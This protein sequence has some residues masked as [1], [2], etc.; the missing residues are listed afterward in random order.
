MHNI[1]LHKVQ[2]KYEMLFN[3]F[4]TIQEGAMAISWLSHEIL[5]IPQLSQIRTPGKQNKALSKNIR[6]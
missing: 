1:G 2:L 6:F 4:Y 5:A 3:S